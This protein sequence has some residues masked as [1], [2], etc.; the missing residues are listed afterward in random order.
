MIRFIDDH[1][2][3]HG[4]E[5]IFRVLPIAPETFHDNKAKQADP[6]HLS[7]Y[8]KRDEQ[9]KSEIECVFEENLKVYGVRKVWHQPLGTFPAE[10]PFRSVDAQG[11]L[12]H[13]TLHRRTFDEGHWHRRRHSRQETKN[14]DI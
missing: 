9:L 7:D 5:P 3:E 4:V 2:A 14:D 13:R 6:S 12:R 11:R 8:G 10:I 1:R